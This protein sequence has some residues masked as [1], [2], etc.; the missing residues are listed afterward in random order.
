MEEKSFPM[1]SSNYNKIASSVII[2]DITC[3]LLRET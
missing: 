2:E 3:F 1:L